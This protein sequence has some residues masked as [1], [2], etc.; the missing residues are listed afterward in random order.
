MTSWIYHII[1][2]WY[3][4]WYHKKATWYPLWYHNFESMNYIHAS[5]ISRTLDIIGPWYQSTNHKLSTITSYYDHRLFQYAFT[6]FQRRS[7]SWV[8]LSSTPTPPLPHHHQKK[9]ALVDDQVFHSV[10]CQHVAPQLRM[11]SRK[12]FTCTFS[13]SPACDPML[14]SCTLN[15]A[16]QQQFQ[17]S[18][19]CPSKFCG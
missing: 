14:F 6:L 2:L 18:S 17:A 7:W 13:I 19:Y 4:C 1:G 3:C 12:F 5:L 11:I 15:M 9:S 16:P 8:P 10:H